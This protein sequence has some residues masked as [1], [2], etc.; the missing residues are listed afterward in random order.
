MFEREGTAG[1]ADI[2]LVGGEAELSAALARVREAGVTEFQA[3]P[4]GDAPT[5]DRTVEFLASALSGN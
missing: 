2:A 4:F 5:I 1:P 3:T